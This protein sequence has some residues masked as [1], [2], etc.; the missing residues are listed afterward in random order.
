M[1]WSV[2][3]GALASLTATVGAAGQ[4]SYT[5]GN[6]DIDGTPHAFKAAGGQS[7][8]VV[9]LDNKQKLKLQ[10][11]PQLDGE[12]KRPHQCMLIVRDSTTKAPSTSDN[13]LD[14]TPSAALVIPIKPGT[15]RGSLALSQKDF[16]PV[17]LQNGS[18]D[19]TIVIGSFGD[20][21]PFQQHIAT[22]KF[23]FDP[24]TPRPTVATP[25]RYGPL[26]EITHTFRADVK[27]PPVVISLFFTGAVVTGLVGLIVAWSMLGCDLSDLSKA[28][29]NAPIAYLGF[30]GAV[31]GVEIFLV[32]YWLQLQIFTAIAA[33][34]ISAVV[35]FFTGRPALR[36]VQGRRLAGSR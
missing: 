9:H 26:P 15:T 31:F 22:L 10:L 18:V 28:V 14:T 19:L 24:K 30:L 7:P 8:L 27:S 12:P 2:V 25:L 34:L 21:L 6:I 32:V 20:D 1:R 11:S 4:W 3:L 17:F 23:D 5:A 33:L 35:A 16:G 36:E 13:T 29:S